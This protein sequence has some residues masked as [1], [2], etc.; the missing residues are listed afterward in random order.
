MNWNIFK[1]D[2]DYVN[3]LA[4]M[5]VDLANRVDELETLIVENNKFLLDKKIKQQAA[6]RAH[7][8]R[9][10]NNQQATLTAGSRNALADENN[11]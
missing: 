8:L 11:Q 5:V 4:D 1:P 2:N 6:S 9:S 3:K 7:Y 10:R